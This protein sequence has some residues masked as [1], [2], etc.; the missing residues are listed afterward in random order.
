MNNNKY[1]AIYSRKSK[2]TGKGESIENQIDKCKEMLYY[3][4]GHEINK[5]ILIYQDEGFTGYNINRPGLGQMLND[6]QNNKISLV[7]VYRLDRISRNVSDFCHLK[8]EFSKYH[9]DF[10]SVT[11]HFDTSTPMG[12]AMLMISSVFAQ[13]ER[14]TIAERIRDN[15]YDLAKTG[16]WLGGTTPFGYKSKRI[17]KIINNKVKYLYQLEEIPDEI[18]KII[19][20]WKSINKLKSIK[21]VV[22]Y[23]HKIHLYT[24]NNYPFTRIALQNIYHNPIYVIADK[25]IISFFKSLGA[26][27]YI[28]EK[29]LDNKRG[30]IA[31]NK[32]M[33]GKGKTH[34]IKDISEWIIA[35]GNHKGII[36][37]TV[38]INTWN[39]L[40][41]NQNKHFRKPVIN[42]SLFSGMVKCNHCHSL[43]RVVMRKSF[44]SNGIRNYVYLCTL[45]EKS[46][47]VLCQCQNINGNELDEIVINKIFLYDIKTVDLI[48][49]LL[50]FQNIFND[51]NTKDNIIDINYYAE[52]IINSYKQEFIKLDLMTKR[53]LIQKI[54]DYIA[55]DE[56]NITIYFKK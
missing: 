38:F 10:I 25:K 34:F 56:N 40:K 45:K 11:E 7:I 26:N 17:K 51:I 36:N 50:S 44:D 9:V 20:I 30:L 48:K 42:K 2:F 43:M 18:N 4:Y 21:D 32:R 33:E 16:R 31:Y 24:R 14:D 5:K 1:Y 28:D 29:K 35:L 6:I 53:F 12:L 8:D 55:V 23:L 52:D 37:S 41:N 15:M 46:H 3:K 13:L 22:N 47:K 54:I 19:I 39:L 49:K 27:I